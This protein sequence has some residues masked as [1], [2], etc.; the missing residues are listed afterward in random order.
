[1]PGGPVPC[2]RPRVG[3]TE[4]DDFSLLLQRAKHGERD[5]LG[6]LHQRYAPLVLARIRDGFR[7]DL[8]RR[9]DP[10]DLS[11][12]VAVEVLRDLGRFE[13]RGEAAFRHWLYIKAESK[14]AARLRS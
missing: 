10:E 3:R 12:S 6:E 2:Y 9:F 14:V 7:P 8:R 5:A 13:D 11:Q 4:M 1:M